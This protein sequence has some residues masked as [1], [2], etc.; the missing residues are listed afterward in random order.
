ML[1]ALRDLIAHKGHA[2]A[3]MLAAVERTPGAAADGEVVALL[4]HV[5]LAN[6]FWLSSVVEV[7]FVLEEESRPSGSLDALVRRFRETHDQEMAWLGAA[8]ETQLSRTI[9]SPLIPGG[10]CSAAQGLLQVCLH[11]HGHRAQC[12]KM[13]RRFGCTPPPTDFILWLV[14][15]PAPAWPHRQ[16][17]N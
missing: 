10:Q 1:D 17:E 2:D 12:A 14:E 5:L 3:A 15:R 9:E 7:P 13:L 16:T 4:H 6:R 11:S 8:A